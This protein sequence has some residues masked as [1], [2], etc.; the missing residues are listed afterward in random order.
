MGDVTLT[1][2]ER[3]WLSLVGGTGWAQQQQQHRHQRSGPPGAPTTGTVAGSSHKASRYGEDEQPQ[4]GEDGDGRGFQ[5]PL[6]LLLPLQPKFST[7]PAL[8]PGSDAQRQPL[9]VMTPR[10]LQRLLELACRNHRAAAAAA[11]AALSSTAAAGRGFSASASGGGASTPSAGA[12]PGQPAGLSEQRGPGAAEEGGA[13]ARSQAGT[14]LQLQGGAGVMGS[15]SPGVIGLDDDE[16]RLRILMWVASLGAAEEGEGKGGAGPCTAGKERTPAPRLLLPDRCVPTVSS[17]RPPTG[18][19]L[20]TASCPAN[21]QPHRALRIPPPRPAAAGT[22]PPP[23]CAMAFVCVLRGRGGPLCSALLCRRK[24]KTWT[25]R[26]ADT[27]EFLLHVDGVAG[28]WA[29][30]VCVPREIARAA[31]GSVGVAGM[32]SSLCCSMG[33]ARASIAMTCS[34]FPRPPPFQQYV[35]NA[36]WQS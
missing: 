17:C 24:G 9:S 31:G 3:G 14:P 4:G 10:H 32:C 29:G 33:P 27:W 13:A 28:G 2:E 26:V 12:A 19:G 36:R 11:A 5:L 8:L 22:H 21:H 30:C 7:M 6:P 15:P 25:G 35:R 23:A 16:V 18:P 34:P 1:Q 20:G